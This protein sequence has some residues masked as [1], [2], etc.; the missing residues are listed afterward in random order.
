M[1]H[2]SSTTQFVRDIASLFDRPEYSDY[3]IIYGQDGEKTM[4]V[5]RDIISARSQYF[6]NACKMDF[7]EG[8]RRSIDLSEDSEF[9][10]EAV[11]KFIY[12]NNYVGVNFD[13]QAISI[14]D[15]TEVYAAADK[16]CMKGLMDLAATYVRKVLC[17]NTL[18]ENRLL[19]VASLIFEKT[20]STNDILRKEIAYALFVKLDANKENSRSRALVQEFLTANPEIATAMTFVGMEYW[21]EKRMTVFMPPPTYD[22]RY[23]AAASPTLPWAPRGVGN[24]PVAPPPPVPAWTSTSPLLQSGE[25][26]DFEIEYN[27]TSY[28]VHKTVLC[29]QSSYF[30]GACSR[31]FKEGQNACLVIQ[32]EYA[33]DVFETVL[34]FLYSGVYTACNEDA[35]Q[36]HKDQADFHIAVYKMADFMAIDSLTDRA[37]TAFHQA[38]DSMCSTPTAWE[39]KQGKARIVGWIQ[40]IYENTAQLKNPLRTAVAL[41]AHENRKSLFDTQE[42]WRLLE[43]FP[44]FAVDYTNAIMQKEKEAEFGQR[45]CERIDEGEDELLGCPECPIRFKVGSEYSSLDFFCKTACPM[46]HAV[47]HSRAFVLWDDEI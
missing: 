7:I 42:E 8:S 47:N 5:H 4:N 12:F 1:A 11:I 18:E 15:H 36:D 23:P 6:L 45:K 46:C 41:I 34:E 35:K 24:T 20:A 14:E 31:K 32:D 13:T 26:S 27:G 10:V 16:F 29:P 37:A 44:Q 2:P 17:N 9:A 39:G 3:V 38:A 43:K 30:R 40:D 19:A 33:C 25:F 22:P 28:K 21:T